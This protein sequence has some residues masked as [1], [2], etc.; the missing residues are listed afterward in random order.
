MKTYAIRITEANLDLIQVLNGG[1]RPLV[2]DDSTFY[3]FELELPTDTANHR[4]EFEHKLTDANGDFAPH[5]TAL[6]TS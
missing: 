1:V 4:I 6:Y 2:Q 3:L 5:I